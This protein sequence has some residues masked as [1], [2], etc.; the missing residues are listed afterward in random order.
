MRISELR[1]WLLPATL[2]TT[3][4]GCGD[5]GG[6]GPT[7]RVAGTVTY[8]HVSADDNL[9]E[10]VGG[11]AY[12]RVAARPVRRAIVDALEDGAV[13]VRTTTDD[14]GAFSLEVARG[15]T[16]T[17]RV[18]AASVVTGYT[19]DTIGAEACDG[20]SWDVRVLDNTAAGAAYVL[21]GATTY[22]DDTADVGLHA[23]M[24]RAGGIYTSRV[25][26]PFAILDT[27]LTAFEL[28]CQGQADVDL[29]SLH[30]NWS[31]NNTNVG[32]DLPA[33]MIGTSFYRRDPDSGQSELYILGKE[34]VDTDEYDDH[35]I[36]HEAG[37]YLE[38]RLF[39]SDSVGGSH[40]ANESVDPRVAFGEGF[41]NALSGMVFNDPAYV[42]T[43]G[44][45]QASVFVIPVDQVPAGDDRGV[46]SEASMQYLLWSL[47]DNRAVGHGTF[48]RIFDVM[49]HFQTSTP[50]HTSGLTFAG[51]YNQVYGRDAE[52]L[53]TVWATDLATSFDAL[54]VGACSGAGDVADPF[55]V[56]ND[57]GRGYAA[58]RAYPQ[59]TGDPQSAEFW[60]LFRTLAD[61]VNAATDHDRT[62]FGGYA[63][64]YNKLGAQ[65]WYRYVATVGGAVTID[66]DALGAADCTTNVL[67]LVVKAGGQGVAFDQDETG[68]TAGCPSVTF[69]ATAG[70]VYTIVV[71][72]LTTEIPSFDLT[73][74]R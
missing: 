66:V 22:A 48:E 49:A 41:G 36:A 25:A 27:V 29:P 57:I 45:G 20:A 65:R 2:I 51:Y 1:A 54:C 11:L 67:D 6:E 71:N 60:R 33:G 16:V 7:F 34:G 53:R 56:D 61:G 19:P 74:T 9:D 55:D 12:D 47:F 42:D 68:P 50:G 43:T 37:H 4:V 24:T 28:V 39:R 63:A 38:N 23:A 31:V 62:D 46:Y 3:L 26:A 69:T 5:D 15:H 8:D 70:T 18:E 30:V 59:T 10:G 21:D 73:V 17:L 52:S 72:G 13:V 35:V 14:A 58:S 40:S 44:V 64:P 32:G